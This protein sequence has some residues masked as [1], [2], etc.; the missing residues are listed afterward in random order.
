MQRLVETTAVIRTSKHQRN[1]CS[2]CTLVERMAWDHLSLG[3]KYTGIF[4]NAGGNEPH[5][6]D[7]IRQ[8]EC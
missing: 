5:W 6:R 4:P 3:Q 2:G 1:A 7:S 8:M